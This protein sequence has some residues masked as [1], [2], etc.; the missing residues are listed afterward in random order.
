MVARFWSKVRKDG[1]NGC[2]RWCGSHFANGY[3][4]F[5]LDGQNHIAA[6][7]S[8]F[9]AH[10]R[11]PEPFVLHRCDNPDC[12]NPEH[13]FEGDQS[14]NMQDRE[15]KGRAKHLKGEQ[16]RSAKLTAAEVEE[17]RRL[18][19]APSRGLGKALARRFGVTPS[20]ITNIKKRRVWT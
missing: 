9:L 18:L 1:P 7:V 8:F 15:A 6:R 16:H 3:A 4:A 2:W 12:V 19:R 17:I 13:L 14:A 11:W 20:L 10:G 5:W